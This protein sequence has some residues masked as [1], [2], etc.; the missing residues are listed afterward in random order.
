[1]AGK[2]ILSLAA[3]EKIMKAAG[4]YR[5]GEDA[6]EALRDSLENIGERISKE[7]NELSRHARRSTIKAE[8]IRLASK[9]K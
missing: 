5:V 2:K 4:A 1:M 9:D 6:K 3:M 8:D 7:A